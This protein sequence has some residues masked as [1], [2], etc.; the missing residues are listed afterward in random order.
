MV[1]DAVMQRDICTS[2]TVTDHMEIQINMEEPSVADI[3]SVKIPDRTIDWRRFETQPHKKS[4]HYKSCENVCVKAGIH[5]KRPIV[6]FPSLPI[7]PLSFF[8]TLPALSLLSLVA[9]NL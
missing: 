6:F 5:Q 4:S 8:C 2:E 1:T 7:L 3:Q 9:E